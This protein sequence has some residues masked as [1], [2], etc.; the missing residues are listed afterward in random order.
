MDNL[1]WRKKPV[2][3]EAFQ[4]TRERRESNLEW[5]DWM[6][7]AWQKER[8]EEGALY[9]S[10]PGTRDGTLTIRTLEGEHLV[11]WGDY[12][13][14]GVKGELYPCKPDIFEMT[15][16][17]VESAPVA[18]AST[19]LGALIEDS[20][21]VV[22]TPAQREEQRR[23]FAYGNVTIENPS[24]TREDIDRAAEAMKVAPAS[25]AGEVC[26][27]SIEGDG[28]PECLICHGTGRAKGGK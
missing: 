3:I 24:V 22:M 23:S 12:I 2:V 25:D 9:P 28:D 18:P 20:R 19:D 15:Y 10:V 21:D 26:R 1:K 16:E 8:D 7:R 17:R 11:W 14:R 6:H 5:P 13:I 4:M 27:C